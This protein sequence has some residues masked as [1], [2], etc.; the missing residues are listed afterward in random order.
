MTNSIALPRN[1]FD[2]AYFPVATVSKNTLIDS[3]DPWVEIDTRRMRHNINH[4]QKLVNETPI[5]AIVKCNAYGHGMIGAARVLQE[6]GIKRFGVVKVQEALVLRQEKI[7]DLVLNMG[8]FSTHEAVEIVRHDISQSVFTDAVRDLDNAARAMGKKALVHIKIDTGLSRVGV[9]YSEALPFIKMVG[10]LKNVQIEGIFTTL[11]EEHEMDQIQI[12]R[13]LAVC[14][15]ATSEGIEVGIK[16]AAS[17]AAVMRQHVPMLDMVRVGNA[18]Y[19]FESER[20]DDILPTM[21]LKT[22][23][24]LI[25]DVKPGDSIAYHQRGKVER[26]MK[27]AVLPIGYAD[28]YPFHAVNKGDVLIR[29]HRH[30]LIVYMSANH[31][32]VNITG[33]ETIEV[34]DEVVLFGTQGTEEISIREVA[35]WGNSSEYKVVTGISPLVPRINII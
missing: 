33:Y 34:G 25:K 8:P 13:L 6:E 19:G 28:G 2:L 26:D 30:P 24:I 10:S 20:M 16:H 31:V 22:R 29:G 7:G 12:E 4:V 17:S 3:Y 1:Q 5:L 21:Q 11:V 15:S 9:R 18:F 14:E 32:T 27:L 35:Q 23:V